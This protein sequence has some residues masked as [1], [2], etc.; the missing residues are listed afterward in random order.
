MRALGWT[1]RPDPSPAGPGTVL[2]ADAGAGPPPN[3]GEPIAPAPVGD[4]LDRA[5]ARRLRRAWAAGATLVLAA[6]TWL[7]MAG[8]WAPLQRLYFDG[9]FDAQ[10][11]A[12]LDGRWDVEAWI[13]PVIAMVP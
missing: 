7:I 9:F 8:R 12:F 5:D 3:D 4:R 6:F 1:T 10:G 11:R 13:W 2:D